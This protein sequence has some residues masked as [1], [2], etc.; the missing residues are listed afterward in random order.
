MTVTELERTWSTAD[1]ADILGVTHVTA[2]RWADALDLGHPGH[3]GRIRFTSTDLLIC[4]AWVM[5]DAE[6]A[7]GA[8]VM[9]IRRLVAAA[10]QSRPG[11]YV[12]VLGPHEAR[13]VDTAA[14]AAALA[15]GGGRPHVR[16]I[17][18][19]TDHD[20]DRP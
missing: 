12:V 13:T 20:R 19:L 1:V 6:R 5:L 15:F 7:G 3:G 8:D 16:K 14:E 18:D 2:W 10:L 17:I 4:R 9:A 11:A